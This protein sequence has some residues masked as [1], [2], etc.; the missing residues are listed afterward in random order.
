MGMAIAANEWGGAFFGNGAHLGGV[1]KYPGALDLEQEK[2]LI[3]RF[4]RN[5]TGPANVGKYKVLDAG[6]DIVPHTL[7]PEKAMLNETRTFQVNEATRIFGIPAHLVQQLDRAT[8]NNIES[9]NVQFVTL[10][11]RPWAVQAEQEHMRKLLSYNEKQSGQYFIRMNL[12]GLLRGD[13]QSR[14]QYYNT[15]FNI[16][17]L[18]SNDIR[19]L[20]NLN[21][22]E[23]GDEYF[24]PLNMVSNDKEDAGEDSQTDNQDQPDSD[25]TAQEQ[26]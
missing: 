23:G 9:M 11:L 22:R 20:E 15:M 18:S 21:K 16:G 1:I 7:D 8:F 17:A 2:R 6:M 3:A 13:T 5:S 25:G 14:A 10:C 12:D 26:Q 19:A 4:N 24:V